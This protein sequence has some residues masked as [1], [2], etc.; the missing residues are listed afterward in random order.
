MFFIYLGE[1]A[2]S[3]ENVYRAWLQERFQQT[4]D[5]LVDLLHHK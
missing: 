1:A 2:D 5:K 4:L 3:V